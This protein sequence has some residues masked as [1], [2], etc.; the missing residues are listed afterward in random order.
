MNS[1][2][3]IESL[4]CAITLFEELLFNTCRYDY[5]FSAKQCSFFDSS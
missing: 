3:A 2:L 4:K 1:V 5:F